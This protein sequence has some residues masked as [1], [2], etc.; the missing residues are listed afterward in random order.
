MRGLLLGAG[1]ALG[2]LGLIKTAAR[3]PKYPGPHGKALPFWDS[4]LENSSHQLLGD[5]KQ[6]AKE[7]REGS[8]LK[9]GSYF[10]RSLWPAA[11]QPADAGML[12]KGLSHLMPAMYYLPS[13]LSL[14]SATQAPE[15][16][17]G[18]AYGSALGSLAGS[19]VGAPLGILGASVGG[20]AG[21]SVGE[22]LGK[23]L[24]RDKDE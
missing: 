21:S 18:Q 6:Y 24:S 14:Y 17:R 11:P 20:L 12:R 3:G 7:L 10:R 13:A 19:I 8:L 4:V 9:P 23:M 5:P 16:Y 15:G 1:S 22:S 2:A